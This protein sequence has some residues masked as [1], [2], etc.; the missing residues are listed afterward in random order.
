MANKPRAV[1]GV[2]LHWLDG[3]APST[4]ANPS[5]WG[6]PWT[7]GEID[8]STALALTASDGKNIPIQSWPLA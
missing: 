7:K 5:T 1:D 3:K 8:K 4:T 6:V 2:D